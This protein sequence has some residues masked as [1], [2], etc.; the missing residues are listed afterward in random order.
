MR[1]GC[2][3]SFKNV[4]ALDKITEQLTFFHDFMVCPIV[5]N[6]LCL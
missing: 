6:K 5:N 4:N 2:A 3:N 1:K